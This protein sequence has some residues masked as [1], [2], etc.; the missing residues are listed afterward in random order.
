M[1]KLWLKNYPKEIP[2]AI[3]P[4]EYSSLTALLLESCHKFANKSAFQNLGTRFTYQAI[5]EK[6]IQFAVFLQK[7]LGLKKGDRLAIILPNIVQYPII[8]LAALQLGL[9]IVNVN[10]LYTERE[11]ISPLQD[12]NARIAVVLANFA[13]A[14]VKV[15]PQTQL[16]HII[17]TE[18][19]DEFVGL[20]RFGINSYLRYI[21]KMVPAINLPN[22]IH[23]KDIFK[24]IKNCSSLDPVK[25]QPFDI[26]FLQY[27]GGTTGIPKAA[28]LTHR[29]LVANVL[30][31]VAWIDN[32]LEEGKEVVVTALPLCHIFSLT[33][34][35]FT[36]MKLGGLSLLITNPR[37][38]KK[39]VKQLKKVPFTV[40]IGVNTLYQA[41]IRNANFSKLSFKQMK[42]S[43]AGGM[44]VSNKV[45]E[46]WQ[47]LTKKPIITGYGLTEAS[48]VVTINPLNLKEFNGSIGLP[49]PSTEIAILD[50]SGNNVPLGTAGELCVAGPQVMQGYWHQPEETKQ[51]LTANG[52]LH[53]GDI[54]TMN[55]AGYL[56]IVDRKKDMILVSGFNVYPKEIEEVLLSHSG[57]LEA[58]VVGVNSELGEVVKAY[59]VRKDPQLQQEDILRF[60]RKKL[61][62]YKLPR[63]IEFRE[64]LPK[65]NLGKILK[66]ELF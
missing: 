3:N 46:E 35:C 43:L 53:T 42:L 30:Q 15:L 9:I 40:F 45:A 62:G 57:I 36:F 60:C 5:L 31:C 21:K 14:L 64:E 1:E 48:P 20:K 2:H 17:I 63:L 10:P 26:A 4:D 59:I 12:S 54:V 38:I 16:K 28:V 49:V 29:N 27:T 37:D 11:L 25:I 23:Y 56:Y 13:S 44:P 66:N 32:V 51:V 22:A 55:E 6:S 50:E 39:F 41:L 33:I 8:L 65:S 18:L 7:R 34:C 24:S 52:W 58:A 61:T 47:S 19:G